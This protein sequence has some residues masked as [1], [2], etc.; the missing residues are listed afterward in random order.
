MT[1]LIARPPIT[2]TYGGKLDGAVSTECKQGGT[3]RPPSCEEG[4]HSL[5]THPCDC[6]GLHPLDSPDSIWRS[7]LQYRSHLAEY[8]R[9]VE[10]PSR[11]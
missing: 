7:D 4:H 9:T 5:H 10:P 2:A 6:E 8:Y 1:A 11:I 3:P